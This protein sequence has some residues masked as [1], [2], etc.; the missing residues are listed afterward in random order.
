[1]ADRRSTACP[2]SMR[3]T[4]SCARG[5]GRRGTARRAAARRARRCR[6]D[7]PLRGGHRGARLRLRALARPGGRPAGR[8]RRHGRPRPR[9]RP[10]LPPHL[11]PGALALGAHRRRDA[12]R[13]ADATGGSG[14]HRRD[15]LRARRPPSRVGRP[16]SRSR[17]HRRPHHRGRH[18]G[19]RRN[20]ITHAD[21]PFKSLERV[22]FERVPLPDHARD[23][24]RLTDPGT[25]R[26]WPRRSRRG[27]FAPA[28]SAARRSTAARPP[29]LWLENE[30]RPVV[31]M[32][33]DAD[34]IGSATE[35]EAYM[36][37]SAQRYRLMRTHRWDEE[38]IRQ[39][40]EGGARK[41]RRRR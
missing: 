15:L 21:L 10:Q 19:R 22:F 29:Y 6:P 3:S 31:E 12:A 27:A 39:L 33:R 4:T 8:D 11:R 28:R 13:R 30:Y 35:T 17:R 38:V 36:R 9:V 1:M 32:L 37:V 14:P 25:T 5:G 26:G 34:L 7:P 2:P 20:A 40:I 41:T 24:I 23:E 18:P 16:G